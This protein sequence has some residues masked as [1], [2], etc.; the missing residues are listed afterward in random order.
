MK[1][2]TLMVYHLIS[3]LRDRQQR[4]RKS[5]LLRCILL[6]VL[7]FIKLV[8]HAYIRLGSSASEGTRYETSAQDSEGKLYFR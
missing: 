7:A 3:S 5:V 2:L 4:E 6:L 1:R 8:A